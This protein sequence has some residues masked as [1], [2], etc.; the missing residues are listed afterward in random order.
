MAKKAGSN[1]KAQKKT[2]QEKRK[3]I[4]IFIG[5]MVIIV[6]MLGSGLYSLG[7]GDR[8][9]VAPVPEE[10]LP[11]NSYG[12]NQIP[13]NSSITVTADQSM[14]ELVAIPR[15]QCISMQA[16]GWV[17]NTTV[18]GMRSVMLDAVNPGKNAAG[19]LCGNFLF[20]K[21]AF[22]AIDET[23]VASL[24]GQLVN[25][26][27]DYTLKRSYVGILPVNLSGPGT[28]RIY[29]IGSTD[30]ARG[31]VAEILLFQKTTD[32][33]VFALE[34]NR[35][36]DGPNVSATVSELTDIMVRG[37][38][39]GNYALENIEKRINVTN[40]RL[41]P[42]MF[43][44]NGTLDNKTTSDLAGLP[45]VSVEKTENQTVISYNASMDK[46]EGIL[47]EKNLTYSRG[48]GSVILQIPLNTSVSVIQAAVKAGGVT[49]PEIR[50]VGFLKVPAMVRING[51]T[52]AVENSDKFNAVM[53]MDA[54]VGDLINITLST[55]QF[56][57]QIFILGGTQIE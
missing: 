5:A 27:G 6:A 26:L 14:L 56:G 50:K 18:T 32:G 10:N 37:T 43:S 17:Y 46:A 2:K 30:I 15:A 31:D 9:G 55:M 48:D 20:F 28:D 42:A 25:Q 41:T 36:V 1:L 4:Y 45:G 24:N 53:N 7:S 52:V 39:A 47:K 33:S 13:V 44:V 22:S 19:D 57:D 51:Q 11:Y 16:I 38:V 3:Q 12:I 21:F 40:S 35:I 49:Q 29:V 23:T 34:R 54:N 8:V